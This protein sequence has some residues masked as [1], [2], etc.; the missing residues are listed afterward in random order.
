MQIAL[1]TLLLIVSSVMLTCVVIDY[2]VNVV[3][4]TINT[5]SNPNLDKIRSI[6]EILL[7]QTDNL[8]DQA[9]LLF[10]NQTDSLSTN[11]P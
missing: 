10:S 2:A 6:E 8:A 1:S 11:P 9:G 5:K 4:T 3:Q 7:N